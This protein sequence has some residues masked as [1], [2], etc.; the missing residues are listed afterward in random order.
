MKAS[1]AA[2]L[3]LI[4]PATV[5]RPKTSIQWITLPLSPIQCYRSSC[6]LLASLPESAILL[7]GVALR[8]AKLRS[9]LQ[10]CYLLQSNP[11]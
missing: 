7:N 5:Q 3:H 9:T 1:R 11:S 8:S 10:S 2:R 4:R 6:L